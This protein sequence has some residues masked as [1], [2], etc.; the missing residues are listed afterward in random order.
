MFLREHDKLRVD[1]EKRSERGNG[2]KKVATKAARTTAK[3]RRA[4]KVRIEEAHGS[5]LR[6][7]LFLFFF[8]FF[9]F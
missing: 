6:F 2:G 5:S 4:I 3:A 8:F 7:L 9:F 1:I